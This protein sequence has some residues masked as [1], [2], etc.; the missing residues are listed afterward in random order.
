MYKS[1][2]KS[3]QSANGVVVGS[4]TVK[5]KR[6]LPSTPCDLN[7]TA[8]TSPYVSHLS[9][10]RPSPPPQPQPPQP[11]PHHVKPALLISPSM[12]ESSTTK[13]HRSPRLNVD[14]VVTEWLNKSFDQQDVEDTSL[15]E[16]QQQP[17]RLLN[18]GGGG[19]G[20]SAKQYRSHSVAAPIPA[21]LD[22]PLVE[23][24]MNRHFIIQQLQQQANINNNNN[25]KK[26]PLPP[27][28]QQQQQRGSLAVVDKNQHSIGFTLT[29]VF[30]YF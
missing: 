20:G 15:Q 23:I 11:T 25:N 18:V 29:Y 22:E 8:A 5:P 9:L 14:T 26:L 1:S 7:R 30:I 28:P 17:Q 4:K 13:T 27:S 2:T 21:G 19:I 24:N 3:I 6:K 16:Q 10:A 12:D